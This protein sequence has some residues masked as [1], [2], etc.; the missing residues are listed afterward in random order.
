M[1]TTG[2]AAPP[3][4]PWDGLGLRGTGNGDF[5]MSELFVP[6][7]QV[8]AEFFGASIY[9]RAL[10]RIWEMPEMS[11]GAHALGIASAAPESFVDAVSMKPLPG[12]TRHMAMG[13][14]QAHQIAFARANV[15]IRAARA[16]LHE[17]VRAGYQDARAH[18]KLAL[19]LRVRLR[20]ANIFAVRVAKE[21]VGV[22]SAYTATGSYF[23]T[24]VTTVRPRRPCR[25][26][27]VPGWW[28]PR[29]GSS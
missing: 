3:P 21:A 4:A 25:R 22:E 27:R 28:C 8:N 23:L 12:S 11:H 10:F 5:E 13:H 16:L 19:E 26:G 6:D 29:R 7:E 2:T 17:T 14:M 24:T 9:D 18:S 15:L 20:E 1:A